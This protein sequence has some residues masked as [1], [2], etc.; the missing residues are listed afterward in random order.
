MNH[1]SHLAL[2]PIDQLFANYDDIPKHAPALNAKY[3]QPGDPYKQAIE[4]PV[5]NPLHFSVGPLKPISSP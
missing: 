5:V 2:I 3:A 1:R 4:R